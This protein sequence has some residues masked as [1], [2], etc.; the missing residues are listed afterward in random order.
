MVEPICDLNAVFHACWSSHHSVAPGQCMTANCDAAEQYS[1]ATQDELH[2]WAYRPCVHGAVPVNHFPC[3]CMQTVLMPFFLDPRQAAP[4]SRSLLRS[5]FNF[6]PAQAPPSSSLS[7]QAATMSP[8][9][10]GEPGS[11]DYS[12]SKQLNAL[13]YTPSER[14]VCTSF[15]MQ[16][17][18]TGGLPDSIIQ[19]VAVPAVL[20]CSAQDR[21]LPSIYEG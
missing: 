7:D 16:L 4:A 2:M 9:N 19:T 6:N 12:S 15:R 17:L 5:M 14:A 1:S 21:L 20:V 18:R 11:L 13:A 10:E 3:W 8:V